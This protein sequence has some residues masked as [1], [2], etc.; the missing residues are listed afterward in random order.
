MALCQADH[1]GINGFYFHGADAN[2]AVLIGLSAQLNG[3]IGIEDISFLGNFHAGHHCGGN[4]HRAYRIGNPS[5][6]HFVAGCYTE[7]AGNS[8]FEAPTVVLGGTASARD[9]IDPASTAY[10]HNGNRSCA[11]PFVHQENKG[12][13]QIQVSIG[14]ND[15]TLTALEF[16][17]MVGEAYQDF[18]HLRF[19]NVAKWWMF[20]GN[21]YGGYIPFRL[22]SP[23]IGQ[24][25][26]AFAPDFPNGFYIGGPDGIH[27]GKASSIPRPDEGKV[28]DF[29]LADSVAAEEIFGWSKKASGWK[30]VGVIGT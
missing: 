7:G 3:N 11:G 1:N 23:V 9:A 16:A 8:L 5:G 29:R 22:P 15:D 20:Q 12:P 24:S 27:V 25:L 4:G 30:P 28:G 2:A 10:V 19:D 14:K 17:H 26:R 13:V 21:N 6:Y 18:Y